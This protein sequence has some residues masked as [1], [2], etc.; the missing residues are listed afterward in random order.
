MRVK[1]PDDEFKA[2]KEAAAKYLRA[3]ET[4]NPCQV[5]AILVAAAKVRNSG[6]LAQRKSVAL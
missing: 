1:V 2:A 4:V 3:G 5:R 6:P